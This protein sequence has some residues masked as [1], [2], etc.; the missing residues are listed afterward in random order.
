[1]RANGDNNLVVLTLYIIG[2]TYTFNRMVESI[3]DQVKF[4]FD[5]KDVDKQLEEKEIKDDVGIGFKFKPHYGFGD[6]TE[7]SVTIENKSTKDIAI[8]VD[9]DNCSLV[10]EHTKQSRRVIR[11]SPD[12]T[13][14]LAVPQSPSLIAPTKTLSAA[15]TAEDV[16]E[17]D[18]VAGTY[19]PKKPLVDISGLEKSPVPAMRKLYKNFV[20][21]KQNLNFSLQ[22]VLRRSD[23][24]VGL[25]PGENEPPMYIINC[26]FTIKKLPWTYALP[27]NKKR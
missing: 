8:Y 10:V 16:F 11:K 5:K 19:T 12:V 2:V 27:W 7:L 4:E 17:R 20:T 26:P 1:M 18:A 22:L 14:D 15:V 24:R 25:V 21:R 23:L 6:L 9:W 3:D 13:R